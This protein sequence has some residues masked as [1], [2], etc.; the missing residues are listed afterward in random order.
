MNAAIH[1][2]KTLAIIYDDTRI[3]SPDAKFFD[4]A[5]WRSQQ[6][7][8]NVAAGRGNTWFINAPFGQV[9]LRDYLRGGWAA[10]VSRD[11][12]FF[13]SIHSSRP[14][15]EFKILA[16]MLEMDLPV[17]RP[18]AALCRHRSMLSSGSLL[19]GTI[20]GAQTLADFL[21]GGGYFNEDTVLPWANIGK[22]IRRFH[23]AGVW[24]AD[25][26]ARNILLDP[27]QRVY[28]IDFDRARLTPSKV[29]KGEGNLNRLMRSL[30]KLW[31]TPHSQALQS[32]WDQL[33]V[34][35]DE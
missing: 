33:Q 5:Y 7:L 34:G 15:R 1:K 28:L 4:L 29:V 22:C 2:E 13:T 27:E 18:F 14:F 20:T 11:H 10:R 32:A 23:N 24:H 30:K 19:T 26:N 8:K 25:L 17:P 31:S 6:A 16:A 3:A 21:P 12:Y 9:V 35:Y